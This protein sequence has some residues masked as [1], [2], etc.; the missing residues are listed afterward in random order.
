MGYKIESKIVGEKYDPGPPGHILEVIY[1]GDT[2]VTRRNRV[3]DLSI[4]KGEA[5]GYIISKNTGGRVE[6]PNLVCETYATAKFIL[7][8]YKLKL[9]GADADGTVTDFDNAYVWR[10]EP[11]YAADKRVA[12]NSEIKIFLTQAKPPQCSIQQSDT[13]SEN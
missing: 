4:P 2:I 6:V 13:Q 9:G 3:K 11:A 1:K 8:S 5:L 10:Q 7:S 12:M